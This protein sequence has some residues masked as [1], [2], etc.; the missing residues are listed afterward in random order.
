MARLVGGTILTAARL[1]RPAR[2]GVLR[3]RHPGAD[4]EPPRIWWAVTC[5][6]IRVV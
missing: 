3:D 4:G 2:T 5:S 6:H 1:H